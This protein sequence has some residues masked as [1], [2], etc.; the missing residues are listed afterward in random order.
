MNSDPL[1]DV[2]IKARQCYD[3]KWTSDKE[4]D[5]LLVRKGRLAKRSI[6]TTRR[7]CVNMVVSEPISDDD[8]K[9]FMAKV[10]M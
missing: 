9:A 8:A 3:M 1:I 4:V 5:D 10:R 2:Y 6:H 7:A